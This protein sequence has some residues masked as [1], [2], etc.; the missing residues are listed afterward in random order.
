MIQIALSLRLDV[1]IR[2]IGIKL[3]SM[4]NQPNI[5]IRLQYQNHC[6]DVDE[7]AP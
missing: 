7:I 6:L 3:G 1:D 5:S 2:S 4:P